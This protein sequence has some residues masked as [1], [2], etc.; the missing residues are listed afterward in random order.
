M[1][2][3]NTYLIIAVLVAVFAFLHLNSK[4]NQNATNV[5]KMETYIVQ[6]HQ[7][8]LTPHEEEQQPRATAEQYQNNVRQPVEPPEETLQQFTDD[9]PAD[10]S[11][12]PGSDSEGSHSAPPRQYENTRGNARS[13]ANAHAPQRG[14]F[15]EPRRISD[16]VSNSGYDRSSV[17]ETAPTMDDGDTGG[18]DDMG[19]FADDMMNQK[20]LGGHSEGR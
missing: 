10:F 8:S 9:E 20:V 2:I 17:N 1:P 19:A 6:Q 12:N 4:A 7:Q 13:N 14:N 16:Q 18:Y 3:P 11:F 5:N 15:L